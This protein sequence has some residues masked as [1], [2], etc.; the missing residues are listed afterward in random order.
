MAS[1]AHGRV[2]VVVLASLHRL[3]NVQ[4]EIETTRVDAKTHVL[5]DFYGNDEYQPY[6][7]IN[8]KDNVWVTS[9]R[10]AFPTNL[11]HGSVLLVNQS[12]YDAVNNKW[13]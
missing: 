7:S 10:S 12:L 4:R 11:R 3:S 6:E 13:G 2:R 8:S 9:R 5:L 1:L